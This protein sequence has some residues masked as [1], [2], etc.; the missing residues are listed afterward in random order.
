MR[1]GLKLWKRLKNHQ[2]L[3][4]GISFT[5]LILVQFW[6]TWTP[7]STYTILYSLLMYL[8]NLHVCGSHDFSSVC[9][10]T[11][12]NFTL[13]LPAGLHQTMVTMFSCDR[14]DRSSPPT[15][16]ISN[17]PALA[18][19]RTSSRAPQIL[20]IRAE[21]KSFCYLVL[22][23]NHSCESRSDRCRQDRKHCFLIVCWSFGRQ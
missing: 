1:S 5:P 20:L 18:P 15:E 22:Q 10:C 12:F 16:Q 4:R 23:E 19:V 7:L 11:V 14:S 13:S 2:S 3:H 9:L 21:P 6:R 17:P 8:L